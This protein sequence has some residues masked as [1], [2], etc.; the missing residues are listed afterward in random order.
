VT[1]GDIWMGAGLS[2]SGVF[3]LSGLLKKTLSGKNHYHSDLAERR[4]ACQWSQRS[5]FPRASVGLSG[6]AATKLAAT[7]AVTWRLGGKMGS[8]GCR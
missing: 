7:P 6:E 3:C 1:T 4:S 2:R 5:P 8:S